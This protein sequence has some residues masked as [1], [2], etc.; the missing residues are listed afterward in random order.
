MKLEQKRWDNVHGWIPNLAKTKIGD[1]QIILIFGAT[2]L[3]Q[4]QIQLQPI[5][6][7]YTHARI[8]GC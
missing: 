1:A 6:D 2:Q 8:F 7:T 4:E 5:K 3:L